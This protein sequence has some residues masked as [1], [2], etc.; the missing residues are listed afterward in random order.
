MRVMVTLCWNYPPRP[1]YP[2]GFGLKI[3]IAGFRLALVLEI[4]AIIYEMIY[5]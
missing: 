3:K 2:P 4:F 1:E 5:I